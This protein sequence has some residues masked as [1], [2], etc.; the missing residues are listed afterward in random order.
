MQ[1]Q[2]RLLRS[3]GPGVL[4]GVTFSQWCGLLRHED[5]DLSCLPRALAITLQSLKNSAFHRYEQHRYA[6]LVR[7]VTI[8][9]PLFIL[10]HWRSGTT[11][12]HQLLAQ[13]QR[14]AF[15]N[16][17]Q[18]AFPHT[19]LTAERI[20]S[21]WMSFFVPKRR[22]M[23]NMEWSLESPQEDEFALCVSSLRSP[24][25]GWV[26]P[27]RR[28]HYGRY[29]SFRNV[30]TEEL[31]E[32]RAGFELFL[33]KLTWKYRRPLILKSPPHTCRIRLLLEMFPSA[34]FVHIHRNPS[35]V[36]HS[37]RKMLQTMVGWH[38]LQ[39]ARLNDVDDW[40][41]EQYREMYE[42]F[43]QERGLIPSGSYHE[44][45][46]EELEKDPLGEMRKLYEALN[47]PDFRSAEAGLERYISLIRSY[48]KNAFPALEPSLRARIKLMCESSIHEW[49]YGE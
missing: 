43:F 27:R 48:R 9:P 44:M 47:L 13:D 3:V 1:W 8:Q 14:F 4:G 16:G 20:D 17:Y 23:D 36:F 7:T 39:R 18:T 5:L 42:L 10:G 37:T 30:S 12:L 29:L 46:F 21:R 49:G 32:W 31:A 35:T 15:P 33:R 24:C 45:A 2:E 28:E 40:I 6:S 26:F 38:N 34:K 22:P 19:F 41:L 11:H 25:M